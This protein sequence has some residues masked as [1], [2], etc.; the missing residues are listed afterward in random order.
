[1]SSTIQIQLPTGTQFV[2]AMTDAGTYRS[3]GK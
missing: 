2:L 3:G 1:L